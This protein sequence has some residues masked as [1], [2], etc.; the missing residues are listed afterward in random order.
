[1]RQFQTSV[2]E[3]RETI[4]DGFATQPFECAWASEAIFFIHLEKSSGACP[5]AYVQVS[6]DGLHWL[7]EATAGSAQSGEDSFF[8]RVREFGG[9]LRLRFSGTGSM[10]A[11]IRLAL[12]E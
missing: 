5:T 11:T 3:L 12:K 7:D 4:T 10:T 6:P 8:L 9:W 1:M 2:L